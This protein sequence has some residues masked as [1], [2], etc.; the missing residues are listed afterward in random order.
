M[1]YLNGIDVSNW[2]AGINLAAVPADFVI[3]KA[4]QGTH[5]VS[6]DCD[7]QYQQAKKA[8][9][10]L[11][12]YHYAEGGD[13]KAEADYFLRN[14]KGYIGE[15][16]LCLDWE[17]TDNPTFNSGKDKAW[18]KNWCDYVTKQT[19]VKP[20]VYLSKSY[21]GFV[22]GIGDYGLWVAQYADMNQTGYQATPW[23]EGAYS[24]AIRQYSSAGR[25]SG[26]SGNLDLN[27]FY[28][29]RAAWNK[30]AGKG[31]ATQPS[32]NSG[33]QSTA[34]PSGST[35][36]LAVAVMQGVYGDGETRKS[37]LG[38]RYNEVQDFINH[39][40]S[41]S[42]STLASEVK[43]GKYGNGDTRKTVLGSRY[44]EVQNI[45][46][47]GSK[48]SISTIADEVIAGKW[49]DGNTRKSKLQAAGYDYNA[50][51]NE[52][53]K[54]LGSG[55]SSGSAKQYYEVKTGDTLSG[56][57]KKYGTSVSQLQSWNGIKNANLIYAGQKIRVK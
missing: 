38:S 35:L 42:A 12:V 32:G 11:G 54:K 23:N 7:R 40:S 50:V 30:Y 16:I 21:L 43:S 48:K 31:N 19:G 17:G 2:Q 46:N 15:A 33:S 56:I 20:M 8:G 14:V 4:T 49:G 51:Q 18:I 27:K 22:S 53:N 13:Y 41:A 57:A 29:D 26:Y 34:S 9:R 55:N 25:L 37:K 1:A 28:G 52:V 24:C 10:C 47:G 39:I 6:P 5:Y 3:M 44:E 45:V 36:D